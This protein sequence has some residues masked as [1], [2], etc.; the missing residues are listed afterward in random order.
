MKSPSYAE[1]ADDFRLWGQYVD[2]NGVD[3][4]EQFD[5]T[6]P[7]QRLQLIIRCFGPEDRTT[8][9]D[10]LGHESDDSFLEPAYEHNGDGPGPEDWS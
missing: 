7:S 3:S 1:I 5:S 8:I 4:K 9:H 10:D 2:P 6:T